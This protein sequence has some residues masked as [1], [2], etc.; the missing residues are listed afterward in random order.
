MLPRLGTVTRA[1]RGIR[2]HRIHH[3]EVAG[4]QATSWTRKVLAIALAV[5][6]AAEFAEPA[7]GFEPT[8]A[9][10]RERC[11]A[12][13]AAPAGQYPRQESNLLLHL[14]RVPC[15]PPHSE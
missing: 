4:C 3:G 13:R 14:R 2:T 15:V 10:L 12:C 7:V 5:G 11:S 6:A 1:S 9:A 8:L